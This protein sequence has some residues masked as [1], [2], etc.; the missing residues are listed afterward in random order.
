VAKSAKVLPKLG[1]CQIVTAKIHNFIK[2][3]EFVKL[4]CMKKKLLILLIIAASALLYCRKANDA[5]EAVVAEPEAPKEVPNKAEKF[6]VDTITSV[7]EW[8]GSKPTGR[9]T[10]TLF[11]ASGRMFVKDSILE[12]GKFTINMKSITVTDQKGEKKL[13]LESHL[14]G[15]GEEDADH[16]FNTNKYPTGTF[17]ITGISDVNGKKMIEGNL[18]LKD[19]TKN[20]KF[21]AAVTVTDSLVT[22]VSEPFKINRTLWNINYSSKSAVANLGDK[23]I[24][25]DIEV[26]INVKARNAFK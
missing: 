11:L 4:L 10:G 12:N 8:A 23:Y 5:P 25:D 26:K 17:E 22:L 7:I 3:M 20:I 21:P 15:L 6:T 16:F 18:T 2:L 9:H 13:Q 1:K 24:D 14:K 19:I